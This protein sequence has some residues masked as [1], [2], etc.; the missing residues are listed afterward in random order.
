MPGLTGAERAAWREILRHE[1]NRDADGV[2]AVTTLGKILDR[3]G[4]SYQ[5]CD[6]HFHNTALSR[7]MRNLWSSR[8]G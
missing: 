4:D 3:V 2:T 8:A 5:W 1:V 6:C 7:L